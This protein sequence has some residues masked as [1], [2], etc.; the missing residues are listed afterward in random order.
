MTIRIVKISIHIGIIL[1][2]VGERY[3]K[4]LSQQK[5]EFIPTQDWVASGQRTNRVEAQ[6]HPSADNRIKDLLSMAPPTRARLQYEACTSLLF[7][8]IRGQ[9][10]EAS[11][12]SLQPPE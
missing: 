10:K 7:F 9:T 2:F 4:N 8:S 1:V 5:K 3:H 11:T 6:P 12:I